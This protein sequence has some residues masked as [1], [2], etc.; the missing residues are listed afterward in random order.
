ML[1]NTQKKWRRIF[2]KVNY[3]FQDDQFTMKFVHMFSNMPNETTYFA[4][5]YPFSYEEQLNKIDEIQQLFEKA[6]PQ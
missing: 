2:T 1:P 6:P 5:S 4:F 3:Y